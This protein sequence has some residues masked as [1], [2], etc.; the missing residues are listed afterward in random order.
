MGSTF[1]WQKNQHTSPGYSPAARDAEY[2]PPVLSVLQNGKAGREINYYVK[3]RLYY[4]AHVLWFTPFRP[5]HKRLSAFNFSRLLK[6]LFIVCA[7]NLMRTIWGAQ[8]KWCHWTL[9]FL[10][11]SNCRIRSTLSWRK[12]VHTVS[13]LLE[14][15]LGFLRI[16]SM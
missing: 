1:S 12:S 8:A 14:W 9:S 16:P 5:L 13:A 15:T 2:W 6:S 4:L 10:S 3:Q 7:V 11:L